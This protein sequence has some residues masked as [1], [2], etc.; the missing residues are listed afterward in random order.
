MIPHLGGLIEMHAAG[1]L[2]A[3][4]IVVYVV[5]YIAQSGSQ[6]DFDDLPKWVKAELITALEQ[7]KQKGGWLVLSAGEMEDYGQYA[8]VFLGKIRID[9]NN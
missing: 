8:D 2:P 3:W 4:E 6:V 5:K 9:T 1:D 7:Y